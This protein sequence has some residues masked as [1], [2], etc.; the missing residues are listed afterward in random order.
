MVADGRGLRIV[1]P[2][3]PG[4]DEAMAAEAPSGVTDFNDAVRA[5]SLDANR[6]PS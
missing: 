3:D 6:P 2:G 1:L 5:I 4:Y